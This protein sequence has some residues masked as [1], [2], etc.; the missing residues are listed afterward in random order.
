MANTIPSSQSQ[1]APALADPLHSSGAS[2]DDSTAAY[3]DMICECVRVGEIQ[4]AEALLESMADSGVSPSVTSYNLVLNSYSSSGDVP[5]AAALLSSMLEKNI[6]PNDVTYATVCKVMAFNGLVSKIEEFMKILRQ[7][8]VKLNIYFYGAL[9]SACGRCSPPDV[10]TAERAF[11]DMVSDGIRPQSVKRCL[12]R[13]VG[14]NRASALISKACK[15][16]ALWMRS[17]PVK[18]QTS[19]GEFI[20]QSS[21]MRDYRSKSAACQYGPAG[22]A[23]TQSLPDEASSMGTCDSESPSASA[24]DSCDYRFESPA[25]ISPAAYDHHMWA[26]A[27]PQSLRGMPEIIRLSV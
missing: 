20:S 17:R 21:S 14:V 3:N 11:H 7:S 27:L 10:L 2:G 12:A 13:T 4:K 6:Q 25:Y 1:N 22:I 16:S 15:D 8:G 9:I 19:T 18:A 26:E 5:K 23:W 24:C